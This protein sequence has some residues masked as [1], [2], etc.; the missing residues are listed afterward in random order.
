MGKPTGFLDYERR[1]AKAEAPLDRI[2]HLM[3]F[4]LRCLKKSRRSRAQDVWTAAFRSA[5]R[6]S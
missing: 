4:I 1:S 3:N 5:R 2:K 6:A